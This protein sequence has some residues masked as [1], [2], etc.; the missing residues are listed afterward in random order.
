MYKMDL[1]SPKGKDLSQNKTLKKKLI[2]LGKKSQKGRLKKLR[3]LLRPYFLV[4]FF[5]IF[6][7][8][9]YYIFI[10]QDMY[11]STAQ[12]AIRGPNTAASNGLLNLISNVSSTDSS[13]SYILSSY[14]SS[15]DIFQSLNTKYNLQ[16]HYKDNMDF[17]KRLLF[18][19]NQEGYSELWKKVVTV[20]VESSS[21]ISTLRVKAYTPE[22]AHAICTELMHRGETL[23]NKLNERALSDA[24]RQTK[25]EVS[26]AEARLATAS[27][28]ITNFR[29][30]NKEFNPEA[31]VTTRLKVVGALETNLS[32][33]QAE[34]ESRL[35]YLN[36]NAHQIQ[37]LKSRLEAI[38]DQIAFEKSRL[39]GYQDTELI[40]LTEK[41]ETLVME[42]EFARKQYAS[43]VTS[44]ESARIKLEGKSS[45]IVPIQYPT[46]PEEATYPKRIQAILIMSLVILLA[47]GLILLIIATV[48]DHIGV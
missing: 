47:E 16:K 7:Y 27:T 8:S 12:Y 5:I 42:Q 20:Q 23:L 2:P 9:I 31:S 21:T 43:A 34:L 33:T 24:L 35:K 25:S 40:K 11:Q 30:K 4:P 22:M 36:E 3:I 18:D 10:A 1:S 13:N 29:N 19:S 45:Y 14:L 6:T 15:P 37:S 39:S 46:M 48:R 17:I 32:M 44:L 26:L 38:K 28:A 41:Y